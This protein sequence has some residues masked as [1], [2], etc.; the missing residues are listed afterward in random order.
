MARHSHLFVERYSGPVA[1]GL[2]RELDEASFKVFMQKF[3]DDRLLEVL[4]P[5]LSP[6]EMERTV[7]FLTGLMRLHMS[8]QEYHKL[9]LGEGI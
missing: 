9:F 7:D 5:R 1:F 6:Q 2:S 4:C 8:D 3:S